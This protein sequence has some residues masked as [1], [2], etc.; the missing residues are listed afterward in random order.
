M[1][2]ILSRNIYMKKYTNKTFRLSSPK[3]LVLRNNLLRSFPNIC[4]F[5]RITLFH[6]TCHFQVSMQH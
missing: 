5:W 3:P 6:I 1:K 2:K 4:R